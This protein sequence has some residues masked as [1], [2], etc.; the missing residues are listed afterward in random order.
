VSTCG[1]GVLTEGEACCT[2][3]W[4]DARVHE[5]VDEW[6]TEVVETP[7][8][9]GRRTQG[10]LTL[11]DTA[12]CSG[13]DTGCNV[14]VTRALGAYVPDSETVSGEMDVKITGHA[15][16][17]IPILGFPLAVECNFVAI[18]DDTEFEADVVTSVTPEKLTI[19]LGEPVLDYDI[20]LENCG[21]GLG[22]AIDE[23]A[24]GQIESEIRAQLVNGLKREVRCPY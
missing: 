22:D 20:V 13:N 21:S 16:G 6:E 5:A 2:P 12:A 17:T 7:G 14:A 18:L 3:E 1:D 9:L 15:G 4:V 8:C 11:C 10:L 19:G 23:L 24:R